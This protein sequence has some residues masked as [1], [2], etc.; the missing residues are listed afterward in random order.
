MAL[1]R[2][3]FPYLALVVAGD[4]ARGILNANSRFAAAAGAPIFLNLS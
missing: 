1:T 4:L 3:T 2:I